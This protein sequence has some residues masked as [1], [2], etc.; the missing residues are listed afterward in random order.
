M[1]EKLAQRPALMSSS[2]LAA[3]YSVEGLVEEEADRPSQVYPRRTVLKCQAALAPG[4]WRCLNSKALLEMHLVQR[5][6]VPQ[7]SQ[8]V[9]NDESEPTKSDLREF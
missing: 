3:I 2:G 5:R 7:Q 9:G 8:K 1:I 4:L 6:I